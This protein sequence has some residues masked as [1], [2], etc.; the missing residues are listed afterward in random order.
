ML[1]LDLSASEQAILRQ[2]LEE[3]VSD[4]G[5][6]ISGTDAKDYRDDLKDRREVLHKV[7]AALGGGA[8]PSF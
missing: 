3:A 7:I 5:T 2:V 1:N 8:P 6:E 4:L